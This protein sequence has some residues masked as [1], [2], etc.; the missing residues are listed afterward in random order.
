MNLF[1]WTF[2]SAAGG[3][4]G[5]KQNRENNKL[6]YDEKWKGARKESPWKEKQ[7]GKPLF[8]LFSSSPC[9]EIRISVLYIYLFIAFRRKK[10]LTLF[11]R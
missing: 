4:G 11:T 1:I 2:L 8:L 6:Q 7:E 9:W 3:V 10:I 5:W